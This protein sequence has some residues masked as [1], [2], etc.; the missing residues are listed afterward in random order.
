MSQDG[1][2]F[3]GVPTC[4]V[5]AAADDSIAVLPDGFVSQVSRGVPVVDGVCVPYPPK[6]SGHLCSATGSLGF[7]AGDEV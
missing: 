1:M 5:Y 2:T 4:G 7:V 3:P 6:T